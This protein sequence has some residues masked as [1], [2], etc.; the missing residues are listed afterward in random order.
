MQDRRPWLRCP[1]GCDLWGMLVRSGRRSR[2]EREQVLGPEVQCLWVQVGVGIALRAVEAR[3]QAF[4]ALLPAVN[5]KRQD[6][7]ASFALRATSS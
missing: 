2:L 5:L 3:K 7:W 4:D 6:L 1:L